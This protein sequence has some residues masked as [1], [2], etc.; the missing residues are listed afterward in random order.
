LVRIAHHKYSKQVVETYVCSY[1]INVSEVINVA[2]KLRM[3]EERG[4][5][6]KENEIPGKCRE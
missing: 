1:S 6:K 5:G 4:L 3:F 2:E